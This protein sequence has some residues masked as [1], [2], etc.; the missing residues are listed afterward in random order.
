MLPMFMPNDVYI[1]E[2][3]Q[4]RILWSNPQ[5]IFW[6]DINDDRALPQIISRS[7]FEHLLARADLKPIV[8]PYI[9][10]SMTSPSEGSKAE[11]VQK[12]AWAAI[13]GVVKSEPEI[14][15]R[16]TRGLLL[17]LIFEETKITKQTVYRWLRRYWQFGMCENALSGRYDLCGGLGKPKKFESKRVNQRYFV[18]SHQHGYC[19]IN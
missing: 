10:V 16:K 11:V 15:Q 1:W 6:I 7:E 13:K 3:K 5:A 2:K 14:Y 19:Q 17:S 18:Y 9:N 8:D 4:I 12:N